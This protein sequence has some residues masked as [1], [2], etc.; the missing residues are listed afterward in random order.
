MMNKFSQRK[1]AFLI[2]AAFALAP[3]PV[4]AAATQTVDAGSAPFN[5]KADMMPVKRVFADSSPQ[6]EESA[7]LEETLPTPE[8]E[9]DFLDV[10]DVFDD[11]ALSFEPVFDA[12]PGSWI[13]SG[14]FEVTG[15][16][17]PSPISIVGGDYSIDQA[18]YTSQP[19]LVVNGS[20]IKVMV[21]TPD[22]YGASVTAQLKI[23]ERNYPFQVTNVA[24]TDLADLSEMF[25][26]P[27]GELQ[28]VNGEVELDKDTVA[29]L[30]V[31][32]DSPENVLFNLKSGIN[33]NVDNTS[34]TANLLIQPNQD[35]EM[36]TVAYFTPAGKR[37]TLLRLVRGNTNIQFDDDHSLLPINDPS[38]NTQKGAFTALSGSKDAKLEIQSDQRKAKQSNPTEE[39]VYE[40]WVKEGY[41]DIKEIV[42]VAAKKRNG[43][44]AAPQVYGG[45]TAA[46]SRK[47]EVRQIRLGSLKS[48]QKIAGDPLPLDYLAKDAK[49]PNLNGSVGRLQGDSLLAAIK[50]PLDIN[51]GGTGSISFD[52]NRGIVTYTLSD[53][54]YRFVPLGSAIVQLPSPA[55]KAAARTPASARLNHFAAANAAMS[56]AGAFNL[57]SRGIQL[58]MAGSLGYFSDLDQAVK[59]YDPTGVIRLQA[60]G[61][62]R[63]TMGGNDYTVIPSSEVTQ[64]AVVNTPVFLFDGASGLA[65]R[66]REGAVQN[67][68]AATGDMN[69]LRL[70]A[71][72]LDAKAAIANQPD[73]TVAVALL[74]GNYRL[75]PSLKLT[76]PP[77][78]K[79]GLNFWQE[80]NSIFLRYSDGK[81]QGFGL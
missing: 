65:F 81:V 20:W 38:T 43:F 66:D 71:L 49:V 67:L 15:L 9:I 77:P 75:K 50:A 18:D 51:F 48:D 56:A 36:E 46:F 4:R 54:R 13:E 64:T 80:N 39:D 8:E 61:V 74:G 76:T 11:P 42:P 78:D 62:I 22:A 44:A 21:L 34:G 53:K 17:A 37:S 24:E 31:Q 68:Y 55:P 40:A 41:A 35:S 60:E 10:P 47:G 73:G 7:P 72:Q 12:L 29:P 27:S 32:D 59:S 79:T 26:T 25:E 14:F 16:D 28:L 23:G 6:K 45:E 5:A 58:T 2:I 57:V 52:Q 30:T 33:A 70:T 19:D 63:I 69:T 1:I 3:L